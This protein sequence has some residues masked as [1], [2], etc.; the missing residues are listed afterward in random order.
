MSQTPPTLLQRRF[1]APRYWPYWLVLGLVRATVLLPWR[2]ALGLGAVLGGA[3]Y[4]LAP[5]RRRIVRKNLALCF[6]E[7]TAAA[8]ERLARCHFRALGMG[9]VEIAMGWWAPD[10]RVHRRAQ[11]EGLSHLERALEQG[12]GAILLSGHF[13]T[14]ELGCRLLT[15]YQAFHPLYRP[16]KNPFVATLIERSRLRHVEKLIRSK[17]LRSMVRSLR[18]NVPVWYAPDEN[19]RRHMGVFAPFFG[20][21]A[22]TTPATSR[23]ARMTGAPVLGFF[24][25]REPGGRYRVIITPPLEGFPGSDL[26]EDTA[27]VNALIEEQVRRAP[28][29]YFWGRKRF[30]TRPQGELSVYDD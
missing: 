20:V 7:W 29:Q 14:L 4:Y 16:E 24:Q 15:P 3:G 28:E 6:P 11:V 5:K 13:T 8:R 10:H 19:M 9:V 2:V 17:D 25:V 22:C 26:A 12:R 27:R 1:L 30:K 23:L 18:D 21:Q